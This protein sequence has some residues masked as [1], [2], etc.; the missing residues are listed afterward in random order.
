LPPSLLG[1]GDEGLVEREGLEDQG[2]ENEGLVERQGKED[3]GQEGEG[4][5]AGV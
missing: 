2:L 5:E 1:K 3:E 4:E